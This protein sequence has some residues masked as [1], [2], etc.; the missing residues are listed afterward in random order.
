VLNLFA[1]AYF[2]GLLTAV[3]MIIALY[4]VYTHWL[5]H[6]LSLRRILF[7]SF[8]LM[9]FLAEFTKFM[10]LRFYYLPKGINHQTIRRDSF[11]GDAFD[12]TGHHRQC[13]FLLRVG[14]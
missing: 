6:V 11:F 2:V 12:G 14:I 13:V 1:S 3:P 7:Y 8:V 9:G 5:T 10:L 4:F